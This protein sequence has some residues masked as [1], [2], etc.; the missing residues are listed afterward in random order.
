MLSMMVCTK[1]LSCC[2]ASV[3]GSQC[4]SLQRNNASRLPGEFYVICV[5]TFLFQLTKFATQ[6]I[7]AL[8]ILDLG[9]TML[10][11]GLVLSVQSILVIPLRIPFTV[12]AQKIGYNRMILIAFIVQSTSPIL[13]FAAP[14]FVWLY[15]ISLYETIATGSYM[16]IAMAMTSNMAP[17]ERQGN[18]IGQYMSFLT[19]GMFVGPL[20]ASALVTTCLLYTSPSP[21]DRT[22]SR[23]PSSA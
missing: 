10:E 9:A 5:A 3:C 17:K 7:L 8:Y 22:R 18:A 1:R 21:R 19:M 6:P 11:V 15:P 2:F 23:M 12:M 14:N 13:Y 20:I 4:L 16:Q